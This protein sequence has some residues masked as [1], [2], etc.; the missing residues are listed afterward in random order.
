MRSDSALASRQYR[1]GV[2]VHVIDVRGAWRSGGQG[3][4]PYVRGRTSSGLKNL[5]RTETAG[6]IA[7]Q[8]QRADEARVDFGFRPEFAELIFEQ[9]Q[10]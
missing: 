2:P 7:A 1:A 8:Q 9:A 10:A 4:P 5:R 3:R 6:S